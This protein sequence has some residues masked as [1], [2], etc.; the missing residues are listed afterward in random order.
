M[1]HYAFRAQPGLHNGWTWHLNCP[2]AAYLLNLI[3]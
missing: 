3:S 1:L 2:A